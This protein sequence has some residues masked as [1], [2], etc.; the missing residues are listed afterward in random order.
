MED[1]LMKLV[2]IH[3]PNDFHIDEVAMPNPGPRDVV[4]KVAACGICGSDV[5]Y[6]KAGMLRAGGEPLPLGHEAAGVVE[7]V[8]AE[9][10]GVTPGMRVFINPDAGD[11]NV[12]GNGGTEGAFG[13]KV[14]VRNVTLGKTLLPIPDGISFAQAAIVEP[15]S[16]GRHGV[17]RGNPTAETKAAV[18]G[19]GPIGLGAVLW[20]SRMGVKHV[21]AVDISEARLEYAKK[22]GAHAVINPAKEDLRARLTELHGNG[23]EV[24]GQQT[25]GTDVFYDMAG[26]KGVIAN[27]ISM[28][29]YHAR[30][31]VSAV[32]PKPVEI[33]FLDV[34]MRE[35]EI[36]TAGGYPN[37]LADVLAELPDIGADI[38]DI[39]ISHTY[40]FQKFEEAFAVAQHPNSAKVM[41]EFA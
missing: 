9:V 7:T 33:S 21:V 37:E 31:V 32:Y 38:M 27:I 40:P 14:L 26:G 10:A 39:Y 3:G 35:L 6:V 25:V 19:C 18:F 12:M 34:L 2:R 13:D 36:T 30:I 15:L 8:G 11:G 1:A 5:H 24:L 23:I 22:M 28:A 4:V 20:L 17:N 29:Q 16:V 41:I